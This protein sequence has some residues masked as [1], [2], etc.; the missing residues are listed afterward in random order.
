MSSGP[1]SA[2]CVNGWVQPAP[3][4]DF[5]R[6]AT[7]ALQAAQGGT[8]Y[9]IHAVRYFAGPLASGGIGAVYYLD[10]RDPRLTARVLLVSGAGPSTAAIAKTGTTGW[11]QGDWYGF[12]GSEAAAVTP[13]PGIPLPG[14]WAGPSYDPV[15]GS[16]PLLSPSLAGCLAGS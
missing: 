9:V 3:G 12:K 2:T 11:T 5:Y 16:A 14:K 1:K 8:G 4:A 15:G 7:D 6:Q 13:L 10:V